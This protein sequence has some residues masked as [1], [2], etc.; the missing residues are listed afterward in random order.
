MKKLNTIVSQYMEK[1]M[2]ITED[3]MDNLR[4]AITTLDEAILDLMKDFVAQHKEFESAY[5]VIIA[6][7]NARGAYSPADHTVLINHAYMLYYFD[8]ND[9]DE[10]ELKKKLSTILHEHR[11]S[12][13]F[14]EEMKYMRKYEKHWKKNRKETEDEYWDNP[15]EKDARLYASLYINEA[16]EYVKDNLENKL[17]EELIILNALNDLYE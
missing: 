11:H 17:E 13:Q 6:N 5:G 14:T 2:D 15:L 12:Y 7:I 16:Y 10:E 9:E 1:Y 8:I 3:N 4:S